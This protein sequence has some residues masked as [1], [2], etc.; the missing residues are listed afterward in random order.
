MA[1][2]TL[3]ELAAMGREGR[4][5]ADAVNLDLALL[6]ELVELHARDARTLC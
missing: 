5:R 6:Q 1:Y 2:M 3:G 4:R